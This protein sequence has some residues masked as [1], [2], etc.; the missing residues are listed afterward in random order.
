M[1][2]RGFPTVLF[3]TYNPYTTLVS[4]DW[5]IATYIAHTGEV[6]LNGKSMY[7]V[8]ELEGVKNPV[9]YKKSWDPDFTIYTWY[10]ART[11]TRMRHLFIRKFPG[12]RSECRRT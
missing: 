2:W 7:E 4:G 5:F 9:V 12:K 10:A 8:T 1:W 11:K 6:Y 3:G